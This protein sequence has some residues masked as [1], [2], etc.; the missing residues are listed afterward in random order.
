MNPCPLQFHKVLNGFSFSELAGESGGE[1][2]I[3]LDYAV[4]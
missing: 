3:I 1:W 4:W 2:V